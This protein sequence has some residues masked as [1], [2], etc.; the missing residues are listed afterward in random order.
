[1][2]FEYRSRLL[3]RIKVDDSSSFYRLSSKFGAGLDAAGR[4]LERAAELGL[5]V[6]GVSFHVGS[7]CSQS[8]ALRKAIADARQVFDTAVSAKFCHHSSQQ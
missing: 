1:M 7:K 5:Q 8:S 3:L 4:L 6:V 2:C